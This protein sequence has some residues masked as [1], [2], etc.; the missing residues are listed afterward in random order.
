MEEDEFGEYLDY[1]D[2]SEVFVKHYSADLG[3]GLEK[4]FLRIESWLQDNPARNV[5]LVLIGEGEAKKSMLIKWMLFH[6][7]R[8]SRTRDIK[9]IHFASLGGSHSNYAFMIYRLLVKLR[10]SL[11][12][13]QKIELQEEKLRRYFNYWLEVCDRKL[14]RQLIEGETD[15]RQIIVILEGIDCF[16][17]DSGNESVIP[18]WLPELLPPRIRFIVTA[19]KH[20]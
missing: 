3:K 4:Y 13:T 2:P 8:E 17:D 14:E 6:E 16:L 15:Y 20:S 10:E 18:F 7:E 19:R 1:V 5:P 12:I 9:F 11:N